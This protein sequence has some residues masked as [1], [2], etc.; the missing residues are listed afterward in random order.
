MLARK[1]FMALGMA[2]LLATGCSNTA[3][4]GVGTKQAVGGVTGAALGGLLGAQFGS[5]TGQLATTAAGAVI[6]GLL[7]SEVGRSMDEV[8]RIQAQQA[9]VQAASAPIGQTIVW[10]N[11]GTGNS[12]SVTPVRDGTTAS[13]DYCREFQQTVTIGGRTQQ[14]YGTACRQ[15]DGTWQ[16]VS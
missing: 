2:A 5:G 3:F 4:E 14:T 13:G 1:S 8:D 10:N 6:G 12:G 7:G 9:Q 16:V 11:P 15:S